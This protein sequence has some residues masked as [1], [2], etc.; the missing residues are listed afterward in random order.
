MLPGEGTQFK[1]TMDSFDQGLRDWP[2]T[3]IQDGNMVL[4]E[5]DLKKSGL[6]K[7]EGQLSEDGQE[8][9]G[10]WR[11]GPA[12]LPLT[13]KLSDKAEVIR[14]A[15]APVELDSKE[16]EQSKAAAT[17]LQ[18]TWAGALNAGGKELRL[19]FT[20][21]ANANGIASTTMKSIDR[22]PPLPSSPESAIRVSR[23][24][25]SLRRPDQR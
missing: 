12:T 13:L 25:V 11:Q 19:E 15:T 20:I 1:G 9:E 24:Y 4:L 18:G 8:L 3:A 10:S 6:A 22:R 5:V 23:S 17:R 7:F 16:L 2:I 21:T 14:K